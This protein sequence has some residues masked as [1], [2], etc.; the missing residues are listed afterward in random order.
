MTSEEIKSWLKAT[1]KS[2]SWLARRVGVALQTVNGWLS[3]GKNIP[4][5]RLLQIEMLMQREDGYDPASPRSVLVLEVPVEEFDMWN[6]AAMG[7]GQLIRDWAEEVLT[8][9]ARQLD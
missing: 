3:S 1:G 9:A 8:Q 7:K 4:A 6:T 5:G 2:R